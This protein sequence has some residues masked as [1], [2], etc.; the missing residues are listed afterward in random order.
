MFTHRPGCFIRAA[1]SEINQLMNTYDG[2]QPLSNYE[3][4]TATVFPGFSYR[5]GGVGSCSNVHMHLHTVLTSKSCCS[6]FL[7]CR[8]VSSPHHVIH[9]NARHVTLP[10][11]TLHHVTLHVI[12]LLDV[13]LERVAYTGDVSDAT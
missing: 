6:H 8:W 3:P 10:D 2:Y 12:T 4:F 1:G 13:T 5:R 11:V 7:V 9:T